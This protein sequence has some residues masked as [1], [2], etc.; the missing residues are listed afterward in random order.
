MPVGEH[1]SREGEPSNDLMYVLVA[2][3]AEICVGEHKVEDALSGT[4][5]GE[6]AMIDKLPRSA[7]VLAVTDCSFAEVSRKRFSFLVSETPSFAVEVVHVMA[8]RLRSAVITQSG[9]SVAGQVR[10]EEK[11]A[12]SHPSQTQ[13]SPIGASS[14]WRGGVGDREAPG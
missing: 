7:T 11:V 4:V 14:R 12:P 5:I 10:V 9:P 2:G 1:L 13:T 6:M 3:Q 8:D